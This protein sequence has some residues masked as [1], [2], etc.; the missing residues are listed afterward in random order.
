MDYLVKYCE[1]RFTRYA[2]KIVFPDVNRARLFYCQAKLTELPIVAANAP[3]RINQ[4]PSNRLRDI[5]AE[6]GIALDT[7][8]ILYQ[9]A[10]NDDHSILEVIKSMALWSKYA[11]LVLLG[12]V[13]KDFLKDVYNI[14]DSLKLDNRVIY[15]APVPYSELFSYTAGAHLGLA[16][17]K[18]TTANQKFNAGA[19]NK[20]FEYL[21]LGI[22]VVTTDSPYFKQVIDSSV[23][24]FA[25]PGSVEDIARAIN[26]A[27][28]N[29]EE[30]RQ[31]S[32]VARQLHLA[33]FNYEVQFK[34]VL[35][36]IRDICA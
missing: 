21:S 30:Y 3:L 13:S 29:E 11:A 23:A 15:L 36:Y 7:K 34:P 28:S 19:S 1:L 2:D 32:L 20:I 31:K 9:G 6:K 14:T 18:P 33:K 35:Q 24:Y 4:L 8:V 10:I 12:Y 22:P 16:L 5:L 27:L 26:L 25:K 17:Y